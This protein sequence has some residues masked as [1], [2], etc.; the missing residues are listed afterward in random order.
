MIPE[1]TTTSDLLASENYLVRA[2]NNKR[3]GNYIID[4]VVFY[5]LFVLFGIL[6]VFV[7]PETIDRIPDDPGFDLVDRLITLFLYGLY[8]SVTE[9]IFKG[10]TLGK[11]IT[12]TRAV[13]LD[14]SPISVKTAFGRGFSKAVPFCAFSA[15]GSPCI[16]WQDKWT[17]TMVIDKKPSV[18]QSV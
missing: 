6:M 2:S 7:S 1:Q 10:N 5:S 11:I 13:N 12:G 16:P 14:G 15:L 4:L 9:A 17:N 8:M 18:I 3:L